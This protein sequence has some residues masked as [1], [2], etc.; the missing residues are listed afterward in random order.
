[1][2]A[3]LATSFG[4]CRYKRLLLRKIWVLPIL[5][6]SAQAYRTTAQEE[7]SLK[8]IFNTALGFHSWGVT[9]SKTSLPQEGGFALP[10]PP[11]TLIRS[12]PPPQHMV[13]S[14]SRASLH[15]LRP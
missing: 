2:R 12:P 5:L 6:P 13:Q 9:L 4:L 10:P 7:Q 11:N 3:A 1:M 8:V 14:T 15:S